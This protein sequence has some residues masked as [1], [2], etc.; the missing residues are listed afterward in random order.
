MSYPEKKELGFERF[1]FFSDAIVAIA[2]TLLALELKLEVPPEHHITFK[3][4]AEPWETYLA[5]ILSFVNIA[6]FWRAHHNSFNY[7]RKI[8]QRMLV[9]NLSWLF[10]IITLPF[11]TSLISAH[12]SDTP[13]MFLYCSNIFMLSVFQNLLWDY[14]VWDKNNFVEK[15]EVDGETIRRMKV[16]FNLDMLNGIVSIIVSFF[17]PAI[18]FVL[19]FFKIPLFVF[20]SFYIASQ[21]RKQ[22]G[23]HKKTNRRN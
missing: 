6:G 22:P 11:T 14:A 19:L 23:G 3:D 15:S 2:I 16:M 4:L 10:F 18:A 12:F 7:I 9:L 5:F 20:A 21:K 13:A 17:A 1:I 8:D